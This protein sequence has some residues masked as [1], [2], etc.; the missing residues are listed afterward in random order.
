MLRQRKTLEG[1]QNNS[2][3]EDRE[4]G[5]AGKDLL[6]MLLGLQGSCNFEQKGGENA[7]PCD[8]E[9]TLAVAVCSN[10]Y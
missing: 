9:V 6:K 10:C 3:G 4:A 8:S 1:R 5:A 2:A 7:D